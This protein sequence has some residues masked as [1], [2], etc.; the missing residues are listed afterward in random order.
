MLLEEYKPLPTLVNKNT[1]IKRARFPVIDAH[2]HLEDEFGGGW[3]HRPF[4]V[5]LSNLDD[6]NVKGFVDLDGGWGEKILQSHLDK[7]KTK[8]PETFHVFG[9]VAWE[10]WENY[11]QKFPEW[12]ASRLRQQVK[13][14]ADGLKIWK[15]LGL[16]VRD[17]EGT[18]VQVNDPRLDP[19]WN[20]AADLNIPV[21]IHVADP[22]AFFEPLD[23]HNERWEELTANPDW[24]FPSPPFLKFMTLMDGFSSLVEKHPKTRFI[25]AHMAGYAEN[26][27]WVGKFL[28]RCPNLSVDISAR[29]AEL[30]RQPFTARKFFIKYADRI[31]FG[32]DGG[33]DKVSYQTYFRFLE[34]EDECFKYSQDEIPMQGRWNI[35]GLGLPDSVL[36]KIYSLN[37]RKIIQMV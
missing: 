30:G 18:L 32:L 29:I 31:L 23:E 1:L 4:S 8:A 33:P 28:D 37:A 17:H 10:A 13:W 6:V 14:G 36:E 12:A 24:H 11:G 2:N 25:G 7:L 27:A 26:L 3:I 9:G 20:T 15:N 34:S 21:L 19:I 16:R 5:L 22:V 35:Y